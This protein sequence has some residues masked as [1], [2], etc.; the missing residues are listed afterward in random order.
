MELARH[1]RPRSGVSWKEV[2]SGSLPGPHNEREAS[3]SLLALEWQGHGERREAAFAISNTDA[4]EN[5]NALR[6]V[7]KA[8]TNHHH[9]DRRLNLND[10]RLIVPADGGL[11]ML[12]MVAK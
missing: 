4:E 2:K 11:L 3:V 8:D 5:A 1:S 7:K 6:S 9:W 12:E 10:G